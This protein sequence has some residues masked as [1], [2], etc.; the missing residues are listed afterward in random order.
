MGTYRVVQWSTG[1]VGRQALAATLDHPHLE[2]VGLYAF[3]A[4]KVGRDVGELCGRDPVGVTATNDVDA[5]IALEPDC[6]VYTPA[7]G[8]D[9]LVGRFLSS[10]INVVTTSGYIYVPNGPRGPE[11]WRHLEDAAAAGGTSLLGT[12]LNPGWVHMLAMVATLPM[13]EIRSVSWEE[14]ANVGFYNAPDMWAM[15]GFGMTPEEREARIGEVGVLPGT[16]HSLDGIPYLESCYVV[17]HALGLEVDGWERTEDVAVATEPV[18]TVWGTYEEGTVAGLRTTYAATRKGVPVVT[19]RLVWTMG[20]AVEPTWEAREGYHIEV[21]GD[22][23]VVV[24]VG[25]RPGSASN[26]HD[27]QSAM[28]LG[29]SATACPAV[30]AIPSVCR[31]E[32]GLLTYAD[33]PIHTAAFWR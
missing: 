4:D 32:P 10:G 8:D 3:G 30:N 14:G 9:E 12:G 11:F 33:L 27:I 5:L 24:H 18:Q 20:G 29:M 1:N 31:A 2:L 25:L 13:R 23:G 15:L 26:V 7:Y 28:D 16:P 6:V 22:P 19:S 17:A 21:D